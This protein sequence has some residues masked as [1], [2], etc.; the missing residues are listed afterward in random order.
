MIL[1]REEDVLI[2]HGL[3]DSLLPGASEGQA[4]PPRA[5]QVLTG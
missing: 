1:A 4:V 2:S 5:E 3:H